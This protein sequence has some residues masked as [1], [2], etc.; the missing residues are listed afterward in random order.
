MGSD[1]MPCDVSM[2]HAKPA[3]RRVLFFGLVSVRHLFIDENEVFMNQIISP[4]LAS[5][6]HGRDT[7]TTDEVTCV[8]NRQPQT[9]KKWACLENGP[10]R[11]AD[12][13]DRRC[14]LDAPHL[15]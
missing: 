5:M 6:A 7:L 10:I 1:A 13:T 9:L 15:G 12:S 4:G 14:R 8:L 3:I 11:L 2:D